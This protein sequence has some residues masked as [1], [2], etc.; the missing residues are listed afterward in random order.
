MNTLG[1]VVLPLVVIVWLTLPLA[2]AN[3]DSV[4]SGSLRMNTTTPVPFDDVF[5]SLEG[6]GFSLTN[7]FLQDS[8]HFTGT[9]NPAHQLLS[10]G[11]VVGFTGQASLSSPDD[12][13]V[14]NGAS[15]R[16]SGTVT[17]TTS[18]AVVTPTMTEPFTLTGT[19]HGQ[20]SGSQ[21]IDLSVGGSGF[22]TAEFR[23]FQPGLFELS[24][25]NYQVA[26]MPEPGT[27]FLL[28]TGLAGLCGWRKIAAMLSKHK[29]V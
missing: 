3:A 8:F 24:S 12:R 4:M 20:R 2:A 22:V 19:I 11:T 13:L 25:I 27:L 9:P 6:P 18:P 1:R 7:N 28:G 16:A 15:Y 17:V 26:T 10:P 23:Q 21:P 5:L 29:H 14:L